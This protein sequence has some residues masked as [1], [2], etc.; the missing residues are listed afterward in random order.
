MGYLLNNERYSKHVVDEM[1]FRSTYLA[2][3]LQNHGFRMEDNITAI[4]VIR[5][6]KVGWAL[7]SMLYEIN[8]L[9]WLYIPK[10]EMKTFDEVASHNLSQNVFQV[11]LALIL[12]GVVM[13]TLLIVFMR[14]H[15]HDYYNVNQRTRGAMDRRRYMIIR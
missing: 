10:N 8:T 4:N 13:I 11:F 3:L 12:M 7:G 6:H 5:G 9:P 14:R 2:K 1:C 15:H